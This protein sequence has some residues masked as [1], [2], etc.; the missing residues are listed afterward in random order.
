MEVETPRSAQTDSKHDSIGPVY[1]ATSFASQAT[2]KRS[3]SAPITRAVSA[4]KRA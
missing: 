4:R 1:R 2:R 3:G